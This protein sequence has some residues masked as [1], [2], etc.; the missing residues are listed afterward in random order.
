MSERKKMQ[1][2]VSA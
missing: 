2:S 1:L